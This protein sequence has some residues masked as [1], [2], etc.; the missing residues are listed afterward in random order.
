VNSY[1]LPL[2]ERV[3]ENKSE[4]SEERVGVCGGEQGSSYSGSESGLE[5][6]WPMNTSESNNKTNKL[7]GVYTVVG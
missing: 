7:A 6:V 5:L 1:R 2:V 4:S 3:N